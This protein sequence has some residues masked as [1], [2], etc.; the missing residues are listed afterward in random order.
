MNRYD[1]LTTKV[2]NS[3]T[4]QDRNLSS[5]VFP[6]DS[7]N[8]GFPKIRARASPVKRLG[9]RLRK[10]IFPNVGSSSDNGR[11]LVGLEENA[12]AVD[13]GER[14]RHRRRRRR[15]ARLDGSIWP[16]ESWPPG[17]HQTPILTWLVQFPCQL[18]DH[19]PTNNDLRHIRRAFLPCLVWGI[20]ASILE[21][22]IGGS[23]RIWATAEKQG[24]WVGMRSGRHDEKEMGAPRFILLIRDM[25]CP[26]NLRMR[27]PSSGDGL[28]PPCLVWTR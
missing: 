10:K 22:G 27:S 19:R 24:A 25:V 17:R 26:L 1:P 18:R 21:P 16:L 20:E 23:D 6:R 11:S 5:F 4:S 13:F 12:E 15:R 8:P 9:Y 7:F 28:F 14:R 3:G 2:S